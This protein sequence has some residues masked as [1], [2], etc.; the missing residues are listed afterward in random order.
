MFVEH[1]QRTNSSL[2]LQMFPKRI[3]PYKSEYHH[4]A[5]TRQYP[6]PSHNASVFLADLY[7]NHCLVVLLGGSSCLFRAT[8]NKLH[9]AELYKFNFMFMSMAHLV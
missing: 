4:R 9:L 8:H 7:H 6:D 3:L 2:A 5:E 1:S